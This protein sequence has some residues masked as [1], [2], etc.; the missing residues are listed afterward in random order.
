MKQ[1]I[2]IFFG[3][4]ILNLANSQDFITSVSPNS[5]TV[6]DIGVSVDISLN[7]D[8][9]PPS[10]VNPTSASIGSV[11]GTSVTRVGNVVSA[12]FDFS[13][14]SP[15]SK[16]VVVVFPGPGGASVEMS[17]SSGFM[18]NPSGSGSIVYVNANNTSGPWDG[19]SWATAYNNLQDGINATSY[20][21]VWVAAGTY[22][23][24]ITNNREESLQMKDFVNI[25]GGFNGTESLI[26]ERDWINNITI[27]SG[28]IGVSS[29]NTDNAYHVV[30]AAN[31]CT[32]DG[33]TISHGNANGEL[34]NRLGGAIYFDTNSPTI[35]NCTFTNNYAEDGGALYIFD[36]SQPSIIN[37]NFSENSALL[38]GAVIC[39]VGGAANFSNC[40][41]S[42]NF[43][44]WRG[45]AVMID[46]GAYEASPVILSD[47]TFSNN[48]TNGNGGGIYTDDLASQYQGTYI[49]IEN[50]SFTGN[51]ATY[52]GGGISNF[53]ENNFLTITNCNFSGNS[54]GMGGNAIAN[55]YKVNATIT[56]GSFDSGQDVDSDSSCNVTI[57]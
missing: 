30:R 5:A 43:S 46:Y 28:D 25:Y 13:S 57:N 53:N 31:N 10:E 7:P 9:A 51:T 19:N 4:I 1:A 36:D 2:L 18:L 29:D 14:E 23:S 20:G 45:G 16:D 12:V 33:F 42:N 47:C 11:N 41:F 6:G 54:A 34:L 32:L 15:G 49:T 22:F 35:E 3:I 21:E 44:E 26:S 24:S 37:C 56:G 39:R 52:R 50:C 40:N 55:D 27:I 38:G 17:L 8:M 48:S